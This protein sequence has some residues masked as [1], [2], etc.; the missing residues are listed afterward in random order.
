[1]TRLVTAAVLLGVLSNCM[2]NAGGLGGE[3]L[4]ALPERGELSPSFQDGVPVGTAV[5]TLGVANLRTGAS[6]SEAIRTVLA[7][8]MDGFTVNEVRPVNGYVNVRFGGLEGWVYGALLV[9]VPKALEVDPESDVTPEPP[10]SATPTDP[11]VSMPPTT[12]EPPAT[13]P[14]TTTPPATTP[15]A[16]T[17][18]ATTPPATTPPATTPPATTPSVR[19][20]AVSRARTGVGFSYWWGHGAWLPSGVTSSTAGSCTGSCPNCSHTGT[21]GADCS[22]Y[23]AKI[24]QIPS[25]NTNL[26]TD[27][28]PYGTIHFIGT[29]SNW[30]TVSRD[31]VQKADALVYN[32]N[33]SG[34]IFLYESGDSWGSMWAYEARGCSSGITH[35]LRSATTTYKA[36][37]R[38]GW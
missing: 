29:N 24:W 5:R 21:Y 33:G 15:P 23:V 13:T 35:N 18:P 32:T 36:I 28:H 27:S 12:T 37:A 2:G 1:M 31:T 7:A 4:Q 6:A 19:D 9:V 11:P 20:Q 38:S 25:S 26:A 14:P 34:H 16:T 3:A 22:G 17:P 30:R 10:A 8:G